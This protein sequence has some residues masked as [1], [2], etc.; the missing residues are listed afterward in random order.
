MTLVNSYFVMIV[1]QHYIQRQQRYIEVK[2]TEDLVI[3]TPVTKLEWTSHK[4]TTARPLGAPY[5][6][7]VVDFCAYGT[8]HGCHNR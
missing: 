7:K 1:S 5:C 6:A 4:F 8:N 3:K 2:A